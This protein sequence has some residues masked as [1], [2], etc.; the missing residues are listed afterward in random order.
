MRKIK[1]PGTVGIRWVLIICLCSLGSIDKAF[2]QSKE[3]LIEQKKETQDD[4][5]YT[6]NI[7]K[8]TRR[9]RIAT[10]DRVR[11]INSRI[12]LRSKLIGSINEEI[13]LIE[14]EIKDKQNLIESLESDLERVKNEYEQLIRYA[15]RNRGQKERMMFILSADNF[16]QAYKRIKYIQNYSQYRKQQAEFISVLRERIEEEIE[17]LETQKIEKEALGLEKSNENRSLQKE[18]T[19]QNLLIGDLQRREK[20]LKQRIEEKRRIAERLEREIEEIIA[21]EARRRSEAGRFFEMTPEERLIS[22]NFMGNKGK[23]PWPTERGIITGKYGKHRHPV[24]KQVVTQNDGIDISTVEGA[25]ARAIFDGVVSKVVAI[26]GANYTV[27]IRHGNF[28]TVYQNL[29]DVQVTKGDRVK[30]KQVIGRIHTEEETSNTILHV[31]IWQEM[32]KQNPEEWL[33]RN[34]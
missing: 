33:S 6:N 25:E 14:E 4:I 1:H 17:L 22:E 24:L 9:S 23:L 7:L 3:E 11:I 8:E 15:Y 32:E 34:N 21:E 27:I 26:L 29:V 31:E 10:V 12:E 13:N 20:E 19:E 18:M 5:E 30:V 2:T 28:L 16:N